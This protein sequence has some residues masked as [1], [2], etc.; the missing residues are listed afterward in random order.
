MKGPLA[1]CL[2]AVAATTGCSVDVSKLRARAASGQDAAP[3]AAL[4]RP[5]GASPDAADD[6]DGP[7]WRPDEPTATRDGDHPADGGPAGD[8]E[9]VDDVVAH[10]ELGESD[11]TPDDDASV[12]SDL[13]PASPDLPDDAPDL[14]SASPDL[15]GDTPDLPPASPDLAPSDVPDSAASDASPEAS[16]ADA[17][18]GDLA[19]VDAAGEA[20]GLSTGSPCTSAEECQSGFCIASRCCVQSCSSVCYRAN[21]CSR[22]GSCTPNA[23][24]ITCG[25]L[26]AVCGLTVYDYANAGTW[27]FQRNLQVGN[28]ATGTD[29]HTLSAVPSE[30]LGSVWIRPSRDS[31]SATMNPFL[32]FT[33]SAPAD[34]YVGI[35]TRVSV[36]SW[37]SGW[38]NSGLTISYLVYSAYEP[39]TTVTQ[40]LFAVRFPAGEVSLGPLACTATSNCSMYLTIIRFADQP[41]G[42]APNCR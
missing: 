24:T 12:I 6:A 23:G 10:P 20:G 41:P 7:G 16:D 21:Q 38:T 39:T 27:S 9:G 28:L 34:V 36:P 37:V 13:P 18:E 4:D 8:A 42:I 15:P 31:K 22:T 35:D 17:E 14:P 3:D 5:P 19:A 26:D 30:L 11:A 33:L 32:T 25:D 29:Q 2:L 40:R 1:F